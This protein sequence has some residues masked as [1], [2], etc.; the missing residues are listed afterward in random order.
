MTETERREFE[1]R[2]TEAEQQLNRMYSTSNG[3][4]KG[5]PLRMPPFLSPSQKAPPPKKE[6][7]APE[8]PSKNPMPSKGMNLLNL[9]NFKGMKMDSDRRIIL[10]ICLLL[11]AEDTDELLLLAL[12]YI[13]L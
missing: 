6:N 3:S 7:P 13:M 8:Q 1:R 2:K 9:L 4:T 11:S 5:G 10:A 12:L